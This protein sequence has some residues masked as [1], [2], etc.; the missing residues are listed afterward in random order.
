MMLFDR[1]D[2]HSYNPHPD[3]GPSRS[4]QLGFLPEASTR[5]TRANSASFEMILLTNIAKSYVMKDLN[6]L[7]IY[8]YTA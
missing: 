2:H 8:M 1:Q 5:V 4:F 7:Y 6:D 3:V